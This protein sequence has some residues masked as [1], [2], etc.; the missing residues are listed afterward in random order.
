[1]IQTTMINVQNKICSL[2][3]DIGDTIINK[4]PILF[5]ISENTNDSFETILEKNIVS[6]LNLI[7]EKITSI[8]GLNDISINCIIYDIDGIDDNYE[9]MNI[10]ISKYIEYDNENILKLINEK[11]NEYISMLLDNIHIETNDLTIKNV[12]NL[13]NKNNNNNINKNTFVQYIL[14][15][16]NTEF[17]NKDLS[18][19]VE[20]EIKKML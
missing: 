9:T 17:N 10:N 6:I 14:S 19:F 2:N 18:C 15:C 13:I 5:R 12:Y 20:K 1:M 8:D 11:I 7:Y 16:F 4:I 3:I